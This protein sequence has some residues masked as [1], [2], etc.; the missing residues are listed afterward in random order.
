MEEIILNAR[1]GLKHKLVHIKDNLWDLQADPKSA[2]Y[3]RIIGF[4][5]EHEIGNMV[6]AIDPEGGPFLYVGDTIEGKTIKSI[7][8]NGIL[9]LE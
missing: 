7:T 8:R 3:F 9:E 4:A 2:G 6:Y 5:G 1:Y